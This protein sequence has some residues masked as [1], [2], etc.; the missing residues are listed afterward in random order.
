VEHTRMVCHVEPETDRADS[1]ASV[2]IAARAKSHGEIQVSEPVKPPQG[3]R[4]PGGRGSGRHEQPFET[5]RLERD[6]PK[7]SG[8]LCA[9]GHESPTSAHRLL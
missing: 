5:R 1:Q 3:S 8:E 2:D 6:G 9:K 4:M 7:A